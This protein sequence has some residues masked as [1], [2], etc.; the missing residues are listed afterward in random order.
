MGLRQNPNSENWDVRG[1]GRKWA[2]LVTT[3]TPQY[4]FSNR[5]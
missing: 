3:R 1:E 2:L 5:Y 4:L